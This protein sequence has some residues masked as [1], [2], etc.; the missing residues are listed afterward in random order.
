MVIL[1]TLLVCSLFLSSC[2]NSALTR[3]AEID[4]WHCFYAR[5]YAKLWWPAT[6]GNA[7]AQYMLGYLYYYGLGTARDQDIGRM[8]IRRSADKNYIPAVLAYRKLTNPRYPQYV[9]FQGHPG[10]PF[11]SNKHSDPAD[12]TRKSK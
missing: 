3:S 12:K 9:P 7:R 5:A 8:W 10:G 6:L 11:H 2:T 4:Y 1:S